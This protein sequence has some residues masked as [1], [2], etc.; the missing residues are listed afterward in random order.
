MAKIG[1]ARVSTQKQDLSEQLAAL[2]NFG[3]EKIFSGKF[4]GN[5]SNELEQFDDYT[6]TLLATSKQ[7]QTQ[8]NKMLNYIREG[9]IV[10]VTRIDRL[11]RSLNQCLK[12]FDVL[13]RKNVGFIAL[14]QGIDTTKRFDPMTMAMIHLLGVFAELERSFIVERTQEGK[15]AKIAAGDLKAKGGRPPKV[16]AIIKS[17]IMLDFEKGLSLSQVCKKYNLSR[18]TVSNLKIEY[19]SLNND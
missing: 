9:D 8:L 3:C 11:G 2:K 6:C 19:R 17:K 15:K 12:V 10:V 14:E 4:S 18:S 13:R 7:N 16:T 5:V 1:Y